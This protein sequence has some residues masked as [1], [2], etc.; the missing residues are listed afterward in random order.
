[1]LS[2]MQ[3]WT[4]FWPA[5]MMNEVAATLYVSGQMKF[6]S[7]KEYFLLSTRSYFHPRYGSVWAVCARFTRRAYCRLEMLAT[8]W[9]CCLRWRKTLRV[10]C[11]FI[12]T[13]RPP[14]PS[15]PYVQLEPPQ[16]HFPHRTQ[17]LHI[18][19]W[20]SCMAA[21]IKYGMHVWCARLF[22][23]PIQQKCFIDVID[24]I[25]YDNLFLSKIYLMHLCA[26]L[27]DRDT[28]GWMLVT[29]W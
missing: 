29:L 3:V 19:F 17:T 18:N 14:L 7:G 4:Y 16:Q 20:W 12:L 27:C 5:S 11:V 9:Q 6:L 26:Y 28:L 10:D 23:R 1:M 24:E 13:R 8:R 25:W 21:S 22:W 15:V 2:S